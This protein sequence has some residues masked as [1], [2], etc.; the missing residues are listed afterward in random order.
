MFADGHSEYMKTTDVG[1]NHDNI[2][3]YCH[4]QLESFVFS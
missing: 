2:Y 3:T 4:F 1:S